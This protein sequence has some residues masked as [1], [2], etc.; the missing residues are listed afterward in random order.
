MSDY[1]PKRRTALVL[2]GTGTSGAYHAGVLKA[3]D[4]TGAKIDL[5]VGS[6]VGV[7][8]AAFAAAASSSK[9]YGPS[10]FWSGIRWSSLYQLRRPIRIALFLL[11]LSFGVFLLPV[12]LALVAGMLFPLVLV[13]DLAVPGLP[14]QLL[15]NPWAMPGAL[16]DPYV[17]ALAVPVFLL[18]VFATVYAAGVAIRYRRRAAEAFESVIDPTPAA[19]RLREGLWDVCRGQLTAK[20]PESD[21]EVGQRL[22][23]VLAENLGQPGF[24]ELIV[25]A[26]DLD[27][28]EVLP[29]VLLAD[30]HRAAYVAQRSRESRSADG[31]PAMVDLRQSEAMLFDAVLTGLLP[32]VL[33]PVR[34]VQFTRHG[35]YGGE[36]HRLT[37][38]PAGDGIADAVIAGAEQLIVVTAVPEAPAPPRR[39][40]GLRAVADASAALLERRSVEAELRGAARINRI[41][42]TVGHRTDD[43]RSAWQDPASGRTYRE[44]SIYVIRPERRAIGPLEWDGAADPATEVRGQPE[45]LIEQGY[46]DAHRLFV[47]PVLGGSEPRTQEAERPSAMGL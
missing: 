42:Q 36:V 14:A 15:A 21:A 29:F 4:E 34:R 5:V 28:G 27:S 23:S 6:G 1:S 35:L 7:V 46:R 13:A 22:V 31:Q 41:V 40:R 43:G 10:G 45:D 20:R 2:L 11:G 26:S 37:E 32:P 3:L 18:S 39:R 25:R 8:G 19:L 44:V 16:R 38:A 47:D 9:L 17:A 12:V 30:P 24:R 33:T